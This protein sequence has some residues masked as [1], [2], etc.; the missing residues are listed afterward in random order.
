MN[1]GSLHDSS[2]SQEYLPVQEQLLHGK[3]FFSVDFTAVIMLKVGPPFVPM[4]TKSI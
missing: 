4:P 3:V 1:E 2:I